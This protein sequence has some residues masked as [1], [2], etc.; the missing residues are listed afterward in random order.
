MISIKS[1][2]GLPA[3]AEID[4][5]CC[6]AT[7]RRRE[8][9]PSIRRRDR[10]RIIR[11]WA[12]HRQDVVFSM[13][14]LGGERQKNKEP[15]WQLIHGSGRK[16]WPKSERNVKPKPWPIGADSYGRTTTDLLARNQW[17]EF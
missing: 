9:K 11:K 16:S 2:K 7:R 10:R 4:V 12:L 6:K 15:E 3:Q 8:I 14:R 17:V 5:H 13:D 1:M